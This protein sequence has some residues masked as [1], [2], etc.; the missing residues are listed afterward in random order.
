MLGVFALDL[1]RTSIT[2]R[3]SPRHDNGLASLNI[4][5]NGD[6]S[7]FAH[8]RLNRDLACNVILADNEYVAAISAQDHR[9][10]RNGELGARRL[11]RESRTRGR[12]HNPVRPR[13]I[14]T[15]TMAR[16]GARTSWSLLPVRLIS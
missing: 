15:N 10:I 11:G 2:E 1:H 16:I 13:Q 9:I 12:A 4:S 5:F 8:T 7:A 3:F 14:D 6:I